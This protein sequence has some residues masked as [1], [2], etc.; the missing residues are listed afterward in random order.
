[1]PQPLAELLNLVFHNRIFPDAYKIAK[2][3]SL[4]KKGSRLDY[5]IYRP[6]SYL[7]NIGKN[8]NS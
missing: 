8:K 2:V 6:A 4:Y 7:S 1:M 5:N 3:M